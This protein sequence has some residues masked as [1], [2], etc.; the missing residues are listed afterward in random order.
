MEGIIPSSMPPKPVPITGIMRMSSSRA[1][2]PRRNRLNTNG[3]G[4][5][6][7]SRDSP[8]RRMVHWSD[9]IGAVGSATEA[10]TKWGAIRK[11]KTGPFVSDRISTLDGG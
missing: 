6:V 11:F 4:P 2:M 9:E 7:F 8:V 10:E 3:N 5:D 1:S